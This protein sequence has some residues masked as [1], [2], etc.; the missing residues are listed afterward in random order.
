MN[1]M[2]NIRI[3]RLPNL[4]FSVVVICLAVPL[5]L[6]ASTLTPAYMVTSC[7]TSSTP[8][9]QT[10]S[11]SSSGGTIFANASLAAL[12]ASA[13]V[14][15]NSN[16]TGEYGQAQDFY[17]W[18]LV[19]P[20]AP[21]Y[22]AV[23][24]LFT[25]SGSTSGSGDYW[26]YASVDFGPDA[27]VA[28]SSSLAYNC[29]NSQVLASFGGTDRVLVS[30]GVYQGVINAFAQVGSNGGTASAFADPFIEIDPAFLR[31]NPGYSLAFSTGI[32]NAAPTDG[33]VPPVPEPASV[34]LLG[35]G[36]AGLIARRSRARLLGRE[37]VTVHPGSGPA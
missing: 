29:P 15:F 7:T 37:G 12:S 8:D 36:L 9:T 19:S 13:S 11:Q 18:E 14:T 27:F 2:N 33:T 3:G 23:P 24:I 5:S 34:I 31:L 22:T 25:A 16:T 6:S 30:P 4:A 26:S 35:T 10:C 21:D 32:I 28:C 17:W 1:R 20:F